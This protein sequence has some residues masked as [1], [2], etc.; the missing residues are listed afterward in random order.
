MQ[1]NARFRRISIPAWLS[2]AIVC[3]VV[4]FARPAPAVGGGVTS[5]PHVLAGVVTHDPHNGWLVPWQP[6]HRPRRWWRN[7]A[8]R[9]V[10]RAIQWAHLRAKWLA[11]HFRKLRCILLWKSSLAVSTR[12]RQP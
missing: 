10:R 9:Q 8:M 1:F 5:S 12:A 4:L 11:F 6:L 2:W 3:C 7:E